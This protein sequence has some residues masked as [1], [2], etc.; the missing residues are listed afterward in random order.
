MARKLAIDEKAVA[1]AVLTSLLNEDQLETYFEAFDTTS[2][3]E[4][5]LDAATAEYKPTAR[6]LVLTFDLSGDAT[7]PAPRAGLEDDPTHQD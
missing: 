7:T 6:K 2:I 4:H 3:A 1:Q 5:L